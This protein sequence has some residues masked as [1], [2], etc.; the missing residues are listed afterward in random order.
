MRRKNISKVFPDFSLE[1]E[2]IDKGF[3]PCGVDE[4][5]RGCL[6]FD[7]TVASVQVPLNKVNL[8]EGKVCDSKKLTKKKREHLSSLI[9]ENCNCFICNISNEV[10]DDVN[11][12]EATKLG[13]HG[14]INGLKTV[15]YALIDGNM[16]IED[17]RLPYKSIIKGDNK[18]ISIACASIIA[19][20]HRDKQ[21]ED[22]H[23]QYP[24]YGFN[25]NAGYGTKKHRDAIIKYGVTPYHR[26]T[27]KG[28]HEYV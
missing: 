15:D 1:E 24:V 14:A 27:F 17:L 7:V 12:L 3:A 8:F 2:L 18:S 26:K 4:V 28:V 19:K 23:Q 20:V 11:I 25:T 13:I 5:G 9:L 10:I 6:A 21:M 16:L 22:L